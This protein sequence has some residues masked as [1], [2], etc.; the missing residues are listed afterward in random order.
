MVAM[1][2]KAAK[3]SQSTAGVSVRL[4]VVSLHPSEREP[5]GGWIC[6]HKN[7]LGE[8]RANEKRWIKRKFGG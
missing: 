7:T 8:A 1:I 5:T 4:P 2:A 3:R 6:D